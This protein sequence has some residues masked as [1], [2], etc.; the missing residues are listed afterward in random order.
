MKNVTE[1]ISSLADL[2]EEN[3]QEGLRALDEAGE[4]LHRFVHS[5]HVSAKQP[6]EE[7][8]E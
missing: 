8:V 7:S 2:I 4:D 5:H 3:K 6:N 1:K